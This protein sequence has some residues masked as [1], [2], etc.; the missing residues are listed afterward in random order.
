MVL[1]V[2][3]FYMFRL[4]YVYRT[5]HLNKKYPP[6]HISGERDMKKRPVFKPRW[7]TRSGRLCETMSIIR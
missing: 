5:L 6:D 4:I 7:I 3:N 2:K 1:T